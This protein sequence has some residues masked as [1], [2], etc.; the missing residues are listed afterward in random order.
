MYL[1]TRRGFLVHTLAGAATLASG[2]SAFAEDE[3]V[4]LYSGQHRSTTEAAVAA[5]TKATGVKVTIRQGESSQLSNQIIEEGANSPADVFYSE[6]SP[7]LMA[8]DEKG[9]LAEAEAATL[10]Q[11]PA[12]FASA[13]KT[14][15]GTCMRV[16]VLAYNKAMLTQADLPAS[17]LDVAT[18]QWRGK[19]GYVTRD[20]FQEQIL[21]IN[22]LKGREAA[23]NWLKGLKEQGKLYNGN[24]AAMKA[25]EAGEIAAA[26][27]NNYY[28][29]ALAKEA[30]AD[31][32]KSA[33]HYFPSGD[34][35]ALINLS[36]AAV[37]RTSKKQALGQKLLAFL[38]SEPGQTAIIATSAEYPVRAGLTSPFPLKPLAD[39]GVTAATADEIGGGALAYALEREA[40]MI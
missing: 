30:G 11:I 34:A 13:K 31:K 33:L 12:A 25:V 39:L 14:W 7:P 24:G 3:S 18:P 15:I 28:W 40:G 23:L 38:V 4:T 6:Q 29:F 35:G 20:G 16:R 10:S 9:L 21:A 37:L 17:I 26:L 19:I 8:L 22:K 27:T 32:M 2:L 5:F 36:P 1:N